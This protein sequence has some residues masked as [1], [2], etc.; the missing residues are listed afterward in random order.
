MK[1]NDTAPYRLVCSNLLVK[2]ST[3]QTCEFSFWGAMR[4]NEHQGDI[5][6]DSAFQLPELTICTECVRRNDPYHSPAGLDPLTAIRLLTRQPRLLDRVIREINQRPCIPLMPDKQIPKIPIF[7][8]KTDQDTRHAASSYILRRIRHAPS[9]V[10]QR[11]VNTN[12]KR[13]PAP[14][15]AT[16]PPVRTSPAVGKAI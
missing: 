8:C 16:L 11:S 13:A 1:S 14:Q 4:V 5:L 7:E 10:S 6:V 12:G 3:R 2:G 9:N 15:T